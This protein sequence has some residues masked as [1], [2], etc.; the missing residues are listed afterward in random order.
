VRLDY[1]GGTDLLARGE[2]RLLPA[3]LGEVQITPVES[4][5]IIEIPHRLDTDADLPVEHREVLTNPV[6]SLIVCYVPNLQTDIVARLRAA[7][8]STEAIASLG[9][10][11]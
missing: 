3:A 2:S 10:V 7:G 1:A 9:E 6:A 5:E 8:H 4:G 11:F